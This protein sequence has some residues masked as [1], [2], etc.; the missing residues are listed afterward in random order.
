MRNLLEPLV[1]LIATTTSAK[2]AKEISDQDQRHTRSALKLSLFLANF[3][4]EQSFAIFCSS[5]CHNKNLINNAR[6]HNFENLLR[7]A[8]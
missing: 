2:F 7:K 1:E 3:L 5:G 6:R 4:L 8:L